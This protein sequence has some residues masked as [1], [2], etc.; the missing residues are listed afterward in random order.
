[1]C[2]PLKGRVIS[3]L[4]KKVFSLPENE[5]KAWSLMQPKANLGPTVIVNS[6]I[7]KQLPVE[8]TKKKRKQAF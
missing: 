4:E 6:G 5:K 2:F 7:L 3:S 8:M 1:M